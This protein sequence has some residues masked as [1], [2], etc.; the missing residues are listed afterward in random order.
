VTRDFS[1]PR[2]GVPHIER[3]THFPSQERRARYGAPGQVARA[4]P[5]ANRVR[6]LRLNSSAVIRCADTIPG[7]RE[8][9]VL[10]AVIELITRTQLATDVETHCSDTKSNRSPADNPHSRPFFLGRRDW[11]Q[12]FAG[13]LSPV[14][15]VTIHVHHAKIIAQLVEKHVVTVV[16]T[17]G[18]FH[19]LNLMQQGDLSW[20]GEEAGFNGVS[21]Q[22]P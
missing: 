21:R 16:D 1:Q 13:T 7:V 17:K 9:V 15:V 11:R 12:Y 20:R 19:L 18:L 8:K 14:K 4:G 5:S 22:F 2:T 10:R 3:D 6:Q